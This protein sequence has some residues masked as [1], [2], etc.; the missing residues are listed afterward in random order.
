MSGK[1]IV[2]AALG[3][4]AV[5]GGAWAWSAYDV[6]TRQQAE[7]KAAL[8]TVGNSNTTVAGTGNVVVSGNRVV[9]VGDHIEIE[10]QEVPP[11]AKEFRAPS[12]RLYRIS[13]ANGALTVTQTR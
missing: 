9:L 10:G 11:D 6:Y 4:L 1:G 3:A 7:Q 13:R 8:N 5:I 2:I 12:G